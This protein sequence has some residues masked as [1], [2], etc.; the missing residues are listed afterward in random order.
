MKKVGIK[1]AK[2]CEKSYSGKVLK[3]TG[4]WHGNVHIKLTLMDQN[5]CYI[6]TY[7]PAIGQTLAGV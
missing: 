4:C 5:I 6:H 3:S 7:K 1:I 2:K